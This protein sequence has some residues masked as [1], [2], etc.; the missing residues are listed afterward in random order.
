MDGALDRQ[1]LESIHAVQA[2]KITFLRTTK[3]PLCGKC[4]KPYSRESYRA[5]LGVEIKGFRIN[6]DNGTNIRLAQ[7]TV[8]SAVTCGAPC[9][10]SL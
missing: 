5:T 6:R 10:P 2:E 4:T 8:Y 7:K 9:E 3:F 1:E